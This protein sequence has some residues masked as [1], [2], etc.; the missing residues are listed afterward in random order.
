MRR[1]RTL[2]PPLP[3]LARALVL[4]ALG[5]L[6]ALATAPA[7]LAQAPI[8]PARYVA[9]AGYRTKEFTLVRS[10]GWFHLFYIRENL[11]QGAPTERSLGHAISRDL[12]T[13]AEQD[14]ILP[15]LPGTFEGSQIWA[16]HLVRVDGLWHLFYPAMRNEPAQGYRLAQWIT[17]ATST[18]LYQWTRRATPLFDNSI[19]P[20]AYYDTTV[21]LG[22]D[23]RDPFVFRDE[24]H[25]EWLMYVSTRPAFQPTAMAVGIVGSSDLEHWSDRGYVPLTLP[26]VAF[27]DVAESPVILTRDGS[28]LLF[29]WTTDADQS[30]TYGTSNDPVTGWGNSQRLR[31]MLGHTTIGWWAAE[32]LKDGARSYFASVHDTWIDFWDQTWVAAEQFQLTPPDPGQVF[33]ARFLPSEAIAGDSAMIRVT[34]ASSAGR[35]VALSYLRIRG[36][37]VD[38][39]DAPAWGLPDSL[40]LDA[41]STDA[42]VVVPAGL[43]DGRPC[44]LSVGLTGAGETARPDTLRV[45][46]RDPLYDDPPAELE[47]PPVEPVRPVWL[48]RL[49]QVRFES[50]Q[51]APAWTVEV[52]DVRG[53]RVWSGRAGDGERSLTWSLGPASA[54]RPGIYFARVR[55]GSAPPQRIKLVV[56]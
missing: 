29:L 36:E 18:D 53:R 37:V 24:A 51:V 1:L 49:R 11:I 48:P 25:G 47:E 35:R 32:T 39:L 46:V 8:S 45:G 3:A 22:R 30:L 23:C 20:W 16:P 15:V 4:G 34:S 26:N 55:T 7:S 52:F 6:P 50:A 40:T 21:A 12:Y 17:E 33:A 38:T 54:T 19:F 31:S 27:S 5:L 43:N 44:L 2:R 9:P 42:P 13:W 28:R 14:T 41:D 56:Y 10:E